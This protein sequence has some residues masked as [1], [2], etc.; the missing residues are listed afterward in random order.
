MKRSTGFLSVLV[1]A[2]LGLAV[3][4]A[5]PALA[6]GDLFIYPK[7]GQSEE[8]QSKDRYECHS[9][10]VKQT[11]F[12]PSAPP[13]TADVSAPPPTTT[14]GGA[15]RGAARGATLGAIGGAIGG[16][17]G[18]GAAIGA[19]VGAAGGA[20]RRR[21]SQREQAAVQQQ[22]TQQQQAA[23]EQQRAAYKRAMTACLEARDYTV[24]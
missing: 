11:G 4:V 10:S 3:W 12:D 1:V 17:A 6:Q 18:K 23:L 20:M 22:Q 9:W 21:S 19:G 5:G 2:T 16:D 15:V 7:K 24:Q 14:E 8:K 13:T